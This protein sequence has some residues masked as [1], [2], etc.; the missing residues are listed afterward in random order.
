MG[1][2][3][4]PNAHRFKPHKLFAQTIFYSNNKT[5]VCTFF[6]LNHDMKV[7]GGCCSTRF[8]TWDCH[9]HDH[10]LSL[11][12]TRLVVMFSFH[13][14]FQQQKWFMKKLWYTLFMLNTSMTGIIVFYIH[15]YFIV[16]CLRSTRVRK[17]FV[18]YFYPYNKTNRP[19]LKFYV[20]ENRID[21]FF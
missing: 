1:T 4:G 15:I 18:L 12:T 17:T 3:Q 16:V 19:L 21:F 13:I 2:C 6:S 14:S 8:H 9:I 20:F 7:S 5:T 10:I 11:F